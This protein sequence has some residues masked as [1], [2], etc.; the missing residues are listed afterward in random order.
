MR[1]LILRPVWT[2]VEILQPFNGRVYDPA[3]DRAVCSFSLPGLCRTTVETS[4]A[5]LFSVRRLTPPPKMA[6]MNL[7]IRGIEANSGRTRLIL[8]P[9][10]CIR[11]YG[12]TSSWRILLSTSRPGELT[13]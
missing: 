9:M 8:L 3:A 10:I 1:V 7:A 4:T 11:P 2:L 6:L 5:F 13:S 12:Q